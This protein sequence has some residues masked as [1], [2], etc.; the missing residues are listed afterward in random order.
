MKI[1]DKGIQLI[2]EFE[3]LRLKAYLDSKGIPT[4]G[5][6]NTYYE[7]NTKVK[8]GD[9]ITKERALSLFHVILGRFEKDVTSL[10]KSNITQNQFDALVS[11]AYNVGSD[12]DADNIA[13]GLGDSTLLKKVNINPN[14]PSIG[15][16]MMKW[17]NKGSKFE[18]GLTKRRAAE[19]KLYFTK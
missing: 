7:D 13:E 17:V 15:T 4:I 16:E 19:V 2:E 3:S 14:D 18:K 8:L 9:V 6:G 1:G 12:I 11:F 10:V 5:Y